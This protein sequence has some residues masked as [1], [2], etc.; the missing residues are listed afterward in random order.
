[1][2]FE[3]FDAC[4]DNK[5]KPNVIELHLDS[6]DMTFQRRIPD[7]APAAERFAPDHV[8]RINF[9][10]TEE[11]SALIEMLTQFRQ[12]VHPYFWDWSREAPRL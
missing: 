11:I 2:T 10:D 6:A 8:V 12:K 4:G 5:D 3:H 1:M 7:F 9:A